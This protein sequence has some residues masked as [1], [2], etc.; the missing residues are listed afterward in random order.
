MSI[1]WKLSLD[2]LSTW[3]GTLD[4]ITIFVRLLV[5][6]GNLGGFYLV[7]TVKQRHIMNREG[8]GGKVHQNLFILYSNLKH[9][10]PRR[11][12]VHCHQCLAL[13]SKVQYMIVTPG[14]LI[15]SLR[16]FHYLLQDLLIGW[17][18]NLFFSSVF[19]H[20]E[21]VDVSLLFLRARFVLFKLKNWTA[22]TDM[23]ALSISMTLG[24]PNLVYLV[25]KIIRYVI[26]RNTFEILETVKALH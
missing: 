10:A 18:E 11:R 7:F 9:E 6:S 1:I 13:N 24:L 25:E 22:A 17:S 19:I 8:L 16:L 12:K 26:G 4:L 5:R 21:K 14:Y 3:G 20:Y 2:V 15:I 23:S